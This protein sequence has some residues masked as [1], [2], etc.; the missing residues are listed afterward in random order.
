MLEAAV[1]LLAAN[2]Y[3]GMRLADVSSA[4]GVSYG[5]AP[6]RFESKA[7]LLKAIQAEIDG[8]F[9][10]H[11]AAVCDENAPGRAFIEQWVAGLFG[12][13]RGHPAHWRASVVILVESVLTVPEVAAEHTTFVKRNVATMRNAVERGIADGSI[14]ASVDPY[15]TAVVVEALVKGIA[16]DW[17]SDT[18]IDLDERRD[19][20]LAALRQLMGS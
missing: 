8:R 14:P 4:A 16:L 5:L 20:V 2:G 13:A 10:A 9:T 15:A 19:L 3:A 18:T 12:F 11:M 7:G 17:F 1:E 6:T